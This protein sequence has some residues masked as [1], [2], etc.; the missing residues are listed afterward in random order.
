MRVELYASG[1]DPGA[2]GSIKDRTLRGWLVK[3]KLTDSRRLMVEA[4]ASLG[5]AELTASMHRKHMAQSLYQA[6]TDDRH[7][8]MMAEYIIQTRGTQPTLHRENGALV[9]RG[10]NG[11][12]KA[13]KDDT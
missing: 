4:A 1:V 7:E 3:S 8:R 11:Q 13:S 6:V 5:N 9:V 12:D 10:L 2:L